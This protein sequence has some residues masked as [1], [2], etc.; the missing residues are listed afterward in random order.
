MWRIWKSRNI[1][2]FQ[3]KHQNW[4]KVLRLAKEDSE[5]W[6]NVEDFADNY[7][8]QQSEVADNRHQQTQGW[9]KPE[10]NWV[11][12]NYD[13]SFTNSETTI[14]AD[15]L[16]RDAEGVFKG[17]AQAKGPAGQTPL[18]SECQGLIQAMQ[19]S[20]TKGYN[21][22]IFE[23]DC[24]EL[25]N[26]LHGKALNFEI[27]NW[28]RDIRI[29]ISIFILELFVSFVSKFKIILSAVRISINI[30]ASFNHHLNVIQII[31]QYN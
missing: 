28:I 23:G 16:F 11:K 6:M 19:H 1:L 27:H 29:W 14:Q 7:H 5:E 4:S 15:W 22:V 17:A 30:L 3:H 26:L 12:C 8:Q 31:V 9:S 21:K 13:A 2:V 25:T 20:W 24:Q 10:M 18:E